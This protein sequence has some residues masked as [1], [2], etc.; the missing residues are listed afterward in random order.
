MRRSRTKTVS[1][2]LQ[3]GG[4]HGAFTWGVLDALA[5]DSRLAVEGLSGASA[6]AMN[7][8]AFAAGWIE[9]GPDGARRML[10]TL[11]QRVADTVGP[12]SMPSAALEQ[13]SA[14]LEFSAR[15]LSPYQLNPLDLNPLR[16]ILADLLDF[17][18]LRSRRAPRLSVG[19]THVGTGRLRVFRNAEL[20]LDALLASAC[21]P[22]VHQAIEI[23]GE[24]YWD[25]GYTANPPIFP[26]AFECRARDLILVLIEPTR[27]SA[28]PTTS[29]GIDRRLSQIVFTAPLWREVEAL[30]H[31]RRLSGGRG[32]LAPRPLRAMRKLRLHL[33]HGGEAL[34]EMA[35]ASRLVP[36][37]RTLDRMREI[38]RERAA[39]WLEENLDHVGGS[40]TL[41]LDDPA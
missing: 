17:E 4:T 12:A 38:G 3:G 14:G 22:H 39:A 34:E 20:T 1:L 30:E 41:R 15:M 11:W 2:A 28:V 26:P 37:R 5:E 32:W 23:D 35:G 18:A 6:G 40:S 31:M 10:D 24:H 21:L 13:L 19:A 9:G 27:H 33:I 7:A 16:T 29:R 8:A 25:G 36:E